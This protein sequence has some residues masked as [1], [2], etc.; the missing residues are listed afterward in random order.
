MAN[1]ISYPFRFLHDGLETE[2]TYSNMYHLPIPPNNLISEKYF[3]SE[4]SIYTYTSLQKKITSSEK[5]LLTF[6]LSAFIDIIC[7]TDKFS[8]I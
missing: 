5:I 1:L 8:E 2:K 6:L 7:V 4:I 3:L